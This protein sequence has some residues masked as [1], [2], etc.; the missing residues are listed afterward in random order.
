MAHIMSDKLKGVLISTFAI[1]VLSPDTLLVRLIN[2]DVWTMLFWRGVGLSSILFLTMLFIY[3]R[4]IIN[5]ICSIGVQGIIASI[6][7][8]GSTLTFIYALHYTTVANTV[9]I[10]ST[11]PIWGTIL[12]RIILKEHAPTR[13]W[14]AAVLCALC[15]FIISFESIGSHNLL[16]DVVALSS[17]MFLA[18]S[19]VSMRSRKNAN[20]M[21]SMC[22][23]GGLTAAIALFFSTET[24]IPSGNI[25]LLIL[26][27]F[28]ILPTSFGLISIAPR[29]I[30]APELHMFLLLE[31]IIAPILV[32]VFIMEQPGVSTLVGGIPLF[33]V[34]V[35]H[36]YLGL[37]EAQPEGARA[38]S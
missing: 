19:F 32:W 13:T 17:T 27:C 15:I 12:S 18:A 35:V 11:G 31:M 7:F 30:P 9:A 14:V 26:L 22:I 1:F 2:V 34:L 20:M 4:S 8:T 6:L 36:S 28:I 29:Y 5:G 23:S 3:K 37:K 38:T 25:S 10:I 21:P 16:G 33:A 24:I